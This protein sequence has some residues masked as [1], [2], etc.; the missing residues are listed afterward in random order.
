[1]WDRCG[2][3]SRRRGR[4]RCGRSCWSGRLSGGNSRLCP[5]FTR[6]PVRH[7]S[8]QPCA[9]PGIRNEPIKIRAFISAD[10]AVA[11]AAV[12][13]LKTVGSPLNAR[14][15]DGAEIALVQRDAYAARATA[16]RPAGTIP[17]GRGEV[18]RID[19]RATFLVARNYPVVVCVKVRVGVD[20]RSTCDVRSQLLAEFRTAVENVQATGG[21]G[22]IVVVDLVI[23]RSLHR[24]PRNA[25]RQTF[26]GILRIGSVWPQYPPA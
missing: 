9:I 17:Q 20:K 24:V 15:N 6:G 5:R 18:R 11:A 12:S 7:T 1:M 22:D 4:D 21:V 23:V 13:N 8:D 2:R 10:I 25:Y 26:P 14:D 19:L 16:G 3:G